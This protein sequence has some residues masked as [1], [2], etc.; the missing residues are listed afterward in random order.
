MN[1]YYIVYKTTNLVNEKFY[2]GKHKQ[3]CLDFDGYLGSGNILKKAIEKYGKENFVRETI[4]VFECEKECYLKEKEILKEYWQNDNCYNLESGGRGGK[5][6]SDES[7]ERMSKS[8]LKRG[9]HGPHTEETKRKM[10]ERHNS[11]GMT[12]KKH[13]EETKRK[14]REKAMGRK[15]TAES[16]SKMSASKKG[17]VPWNKG[18]KFKE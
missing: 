12:G 4:A 10:S 15:H 11:L 2:I 17:K 14:M 13:S 8:A 7:R 1:I 16:R 6:V 3:T 18:L 9:S 5:T